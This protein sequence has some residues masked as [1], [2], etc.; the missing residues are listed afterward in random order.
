VQPVNGAATGA[1]IFDLD[2]TLVDSAADL[3]TAASALAVELGGRPLT[4]DEVVGMVGEGA[5]LLVQRALRAAGLDPG[6]P[7]ALDRFLALYDERLLDTTR[8]YPGLRPALR[9]LD[10]L[11]ALAVLTN[12]PRRPTERL[13]DALQV[14]EAFVEVVAGD[15]PLP[16][17]P[18]PAGLLS[19]RRHGAGGPV[20][21]VGDSPVDAETARRG[22]VPFVLAGYGFGVSA[23]DRVPTEFVA[24]SA[25]DLPAV[26]DAAL[27]TAGRRIC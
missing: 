13:L 25:A 4:R 7:G 10:P 14:R 6:T 24:A 2:G 16:R 20:V 18:D 23:F 19:L 1:V 12:K 26:I 9:A 11:L 27:A 15:G 5:A 21:L 17:K 8:L 22:A 3:A